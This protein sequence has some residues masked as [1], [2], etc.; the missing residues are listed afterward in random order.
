MQ[1][2]HINKQVLYNIILF[3]TG[4]TVLSM[5]MILSVSWYISAFL[6][7]PLKYLQRQSSFPVVV[8]GWIAD[9][10]TD[11]I[12]H[13][14]GFLPLHR[15]TSVYSYSQPEIYWHNNEYYYDTITIPQN[16][17]IITSTVPHNPYL[18]LRED[19]VG[20]PFPCLLWSCSTDIPDEYIIDIKYHGCITGKPDFSNQLVVLQARGLPLIP[21]NVPFIKSMLFWC[22][23]IT[24]LCMPGYCY[25]LYRHCM[26]KWRGYCTI[27]GY[28]LHCATSE[29]CPECGCTQSANAYLLPNRYAYTLLLISLFLI[30]I[31]IIFAMNFSY[32]PN[33][34]PLHTAV[35]K[36]NYVSAQ[37][38]LNTGFK[39]DTLLETTV[40]DPGGINRAN[41]LCYITPL[42]LA[43]RNA[44][45][46]MVRLLIKY[47]ADVNRDY[48]NGLTPVML[49]AR[50]GNTDILRLLI[51][52]GADISK[53]LT[54][55]GDT[56]LIMAASAGYKECVEMLIDAGADINLKNDD[57]MSAIMGAAAYG[58]TQVLE[59]LIIQDSNTNISH[60]ESL[61]TS[62]MF[63]LLGLNYAP[64]DTHERMLES[65]H[66]LLAAG[67]DISGNNKW[68]YPAI[69]VAV[70]AGNI[71]AVKLLLEYG[72]DL[73]WKDENKCTLLFYV[74]EVPDNIELFKA[75]I[76]M[77]IDPNIQDSDGRTI[78]MNCVD[79]ELP[80]F[81]K[82]LMESGADPTIVDSEGNTAF[83]IA[84]QSS[85][86]KVLLNILNYLKG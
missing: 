60:S 86:N 70:T 25:R 15:T 46:E 57:G 1:T 52:A 82:L 47:G 58:H 30:F 36:K 14:F 62:L 79:A 56:A 8:D 54:R 48:T 74:N 23:F 76:D 69:R 24:T 49:A 73:N 17:D 59:N 27:C 19:I 66:I 67:A 85:M 38:I 34:T 7:P 77:G 37:S 42:Q 68:G 12:E 39:V 9:T 45:T 16:L 5:V 83:T 35:N 4:V 18:K 29:I 2:L 41:Y 65:I 55:T 32:N 78:L 20:F 10:T 53:I 3:I 71:E 72:A 28:N 81:V 44:D 31:D 84:G 61:S 13:R 6:S 80:E 75:L 21:V 63:S 26:R 11:Y 50:S 22:A 33:E 64:L 51:E 43:I 40:V